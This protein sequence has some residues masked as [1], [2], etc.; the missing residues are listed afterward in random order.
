M[1][2]AASLLEVAG[3]LVAALKGLAAAALPLAVDVVAT[4]VV[5]ALRVAVVRLVVDVQ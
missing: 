3:P 4:R 5:A 1:A 2:P